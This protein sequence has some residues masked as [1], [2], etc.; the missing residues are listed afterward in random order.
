MNRPVAT[1]STPTS[2]EPAAQPLSASR[3]GAPKIAVLL[4]CYNEE[5]AIGKVVADFRA[6][7][8]NATVYVYDNRSTDRTAE[9]ARAAGAVVRREERPG[10]GNV[11]RRMFQD[12]EA[13]VYVMADGD[14]TYDA[15]FAPALVQKVLEDRLDMVVGRRIETHIDAYRGGHRL[16]N[17]VLTGLVGMLFGSHLEDMLS[18][19]RA[20]SRRFVK[21]FPSSSR[22][23]E[24]ETELTVHAMQ[25][26][27]ACAEVETPYK[28]RPMG[29]VSKLR[30]FRDGWRILMAITNLVRSKRP[31]M[32]FVTIAMLLWIVA[33]VLGIPVVLAWL[34]TGQVNRIPTAVLSSGIV[35]VGVISFATGLILDLVAHVRREV[36]L[37]AYLSVPAPG[38]GPESPPAETPPV[39]KAEA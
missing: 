2:H 34:D 25:M 22:E 18:G 11:V 5:V 32:F 36:K 29:S 19:Y 12:I 26:H 23:F 15:S 17:R 6:A 37:L 21:S 7:L 24:I 16:G 10:K 14:D 28:E 38:A 31:L 39:K 1:S 8:P 3:P 20:F 13:D 4:P 27:M 30:T 35:V 9:V 33:L